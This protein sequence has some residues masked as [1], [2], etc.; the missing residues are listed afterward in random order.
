MAD[1]E[2]E[3]PPGNEAFKLLVEREAARELYGA[4]RLAL[5]FAAASEDSASAE[6]DKTVDDNF[7]MIIRR[8]SATELL[9]TLATPFGLPLGPAG[10]A[11]EEA[12]AE[13]VVMVEVGRSTA[14][15][16]LS[17]VTV[18]LGAVSPPAG[19]EQAKRGDAVEIAVSK[20]TAVDVLNALV[21]NLGPVPAGKGGKGGLQG[22]TD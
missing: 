17:A 15:L 11:N 21:I 3:Q 16:I 9:N 13:D 1:H 19:G 6:P 20:F 12:D 8:R 2:L 7:L 14:S 10:T 18:T 22:E 5:G 4:V